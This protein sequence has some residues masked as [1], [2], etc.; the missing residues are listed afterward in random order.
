MP[1]DLDIPAELERR[2]ARLAAI[3]A[4]KAELEARAAERDAAEQA[5]YE[6]KVKA[7]A[8]KARDTGKPPRGK[9]P[10]PPTPGARP[11]DQLN[12]T[13]P[14]SRIMP[15]AGGGFEQC[16]N[17]Q[18]AVD[19]DTLLVV[20]THVTQAANDKRQLAPALATLN[21]LPAELGEVTRLLAD[22]GY[23]S[24]ANVSACVNL[25]IEPL[26]ASRR[27]R[28]H[29]PWHARF[30]EPPPL[31][32][33]ATAIERMTHRLQT[34]DGRARYALRKQTVEP[35]FGIIKAVMGFRQ[36]L[37][38]GRAAVRGEWSLVTMAWNIRRLAALQA[39][40]SG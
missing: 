23:R 16:Y 3:R 12:L 18:A 28:H 10:V 8:D 38:R 20:A 34:R 11:D 30:G 37:L 19:T 7:R 35:V 27:E 1:P 21:A 32:T 24:A 29:L 13:D 40:A 15:V 14:D 17:A 9:P 33:P 2:E 36:F 4:A 25:G 31:I 6:A 26:L 39:A 22:T 5:A